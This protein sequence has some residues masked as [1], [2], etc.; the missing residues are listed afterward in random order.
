MGS[1]VEGA[2]NGQMNFF[3][4]GVVAELI[5]ADFQPVSDWRQRVGVPVKT[6]TWCIQEP[7]EG[8]GSNVNSSLWPINRI[9]GCNAQALPLHCSPTQARLGHPHHGQPLAVF[10]DSPGLFPRQSTSIVADGEIS[11]HLVTLP[12]CCG[13]AVLCHNL[14]L[15]RT[16]RCAQP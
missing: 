1:G 14:C 2:P 11:G 6:F 9:F 13:R 3:L 5:V 12:I 4:G 15:S 16:G 10:C 7:P 8:A